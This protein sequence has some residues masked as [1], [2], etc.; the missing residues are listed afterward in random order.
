MMNSLAEKA[1]AVEGEKKETCHVFWNVN[2][3]S[4]RRA[5]LYFRSVRPRKRYEKV[6]E[7]NS[8]SALFGSW[9]FYGK[10]VFKF[11]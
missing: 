2:A 4:I 11:S 7:G 8:P 9:F 6:L 10:D 3:G 1:Q 5:S